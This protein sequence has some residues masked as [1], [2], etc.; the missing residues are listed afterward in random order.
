M[1]ERRYIDR[2]FMDEFKE[3]YATSFKSYSAMCI[4][5][6][7]FTATPRGLR[8]SLTRLD[9]EILAMP[10]GYSEKCSQFSEGYLGFMVV[11]P[12]P[13]TRIGRTVIRHPKHQRDDDNRRGFPCTRVYKAHLK[14][15]ELSVC[16]LPFQQQD[17]GMSACAST[18]LWASMNQYAEYE[19]F[20]VPSPAAI[21]KFAAGHMSSFGRSIPQERGLTSAQMCKA[22][23]AAGLSPYLVPFDTSGIPVIKSLIYS[24]VRSGFAP[25]LLLENPKSA[26]AVA[27][28]G[29]SLSGP[30]KSTVRMAIHVEEEASRMKALYINDDRCGPYQSAIL[31]GRQL[32]VKTLKGDDPWKVTHMIVPL[33]PKIRLAFA[34][35]SKFATRL[36]ETVGFARF[37]KAEANGNPKK[38]RLEYWITKSR[39]YRQ[40]ALYSQNRLVTAEARRRLNDEN[41][42]SRYV[43]VVRLSDKSIG[44][45]DVVL[46]VT[47]TNRHLNVW[48]ILGR[49]GLTPWGRILV[50]DLGRHYGA[51]TLAD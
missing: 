20:Q 21:T 29:M 43:G 4:R 38:I 46:D 2:T 31:R 3:F 45:I 32:I 37:L 35:L 24:V 1:I 12:L 25:I 19:P 50:Q 18:A 36:A 13:A 22:I 8:A 44:T 14:G 15:L 49:N 34:D 42:F 11:K 33:H 39:L 40:H 5:L 26:H 6:H 7:F 51:R 10:D 48:L 27:V 9:T 47:N 28:A 30:P 16:G 23:E 41:D 17:G